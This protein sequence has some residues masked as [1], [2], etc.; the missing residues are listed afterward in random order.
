M[1]QDQNR[2]PT[3]E[4]RIIKGDQENQTRIKYLKEIT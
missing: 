4:N 2:K 3:L 1:I